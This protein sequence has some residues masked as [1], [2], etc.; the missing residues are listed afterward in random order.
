MPRVCIGVPVYNGERWLRQA[1][2]SLLG[3]TLHDLELVISDN[4]STDD[5][6]RICREYVASDPRVHYYRN[7]ENVGVAS[8]Y[9]AV[10]RR[11]SAPY[12][13]WAS[14]SDRCDPTMVEKCVAVLE[15]RRDVVLCCPRTRLIDSEGRT[16]EDATDDVELLDDDPV[17]RFERFHH[18]LRRNNAMN[19]VMRAESLRRTSLY[20]TFF[21]ADV[22][23]MAELA[24]HGKFA[25]VSEYLF[26]RRLD[27]GSATELWSVAEVAKCYRPATKKPMRLQTWRQHLAYLALPAR[28]PLGLRERLRLLL[29]VGRGM[30]WARAK[31]VRD[32]VDAVQGVSAR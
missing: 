9:N 23:M 24:L 3:Q 14:A 19:G 18:T 28:A 5:T 7:P 16:I 25:L 1:L 15:A 30:V 8:N 17:A 6:A 22:N 10:F 32:L 20:R 11:A 27:R 21:S 31:L 2:D 4:A 13:K 26:F 12:F 29:R